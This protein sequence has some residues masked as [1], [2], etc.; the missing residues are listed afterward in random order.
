[1]RVV[2]VAEGIVHHM[3]T[4]VKPG[5][6]ELN[7]VA[8]LDTFLSADDNCVLGRLLLFMLFTSYL[9]QDNVQVNMESV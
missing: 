4:I 2:C 7:S 6:V 1:M 3:R 5:S 9:E 8:E